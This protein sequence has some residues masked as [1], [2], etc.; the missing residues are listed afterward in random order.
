MATAIGSKVVLTQDVDSYPTVYVKAGATGTLTRI[1]SEGCYWVKLDQHVADL[2][3]WDNE[4]AIWD[5]SFENGNNPHPEAYIKPDFA[6]MDAKALNDWYQE[7]VGYR[8]QEDDPTMTVESLR[9][10]CCEY[11]SEAGL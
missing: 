4:L 2:D 9:E 10:L 6:A 5:W 8:P 3:E 7:A 1:D 11:A